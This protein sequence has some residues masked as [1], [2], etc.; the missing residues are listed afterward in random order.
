MP[1]PRVHLSGNARIA[2]FLWMVAIGTAFAII[3]AATVKAGAAVMSVREAPEILLIPPT[4]YLLA[5]LLLSAASIVLSVL[6]IV[7]A[8]GW[9]RAPRRGL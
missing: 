1:K 7:M 8:S 3:M 9:A 2:I 5:A 4:G 6:A